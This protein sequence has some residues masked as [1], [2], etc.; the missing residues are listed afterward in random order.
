MA[1]DTTLTSAT[2]HPA[3][4]AIAEPHKEV[5]AAPEQVRTD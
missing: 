5:T 3:D 2:T 4:N 1:A